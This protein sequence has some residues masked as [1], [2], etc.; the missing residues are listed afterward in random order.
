[1]RE[2]FDF[3]LTKLGHWLFGDFVDN[4]FG[5]FTSDFY[6]MEFPWLT[7]MTQI[8]IH[9]NFL[10]SH[11]LMEDRKAPLCLL[12]KT[13]SEQGLSIVL[14]SQIVIII[15]ITVVTIVVGWLLF[16]WI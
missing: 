6:A 16:I 12:T 13:E 4:T 1:M 10:L 8:Y 2:M 14:I 5:G 11:V 15:I 7:H 9:D 3:C